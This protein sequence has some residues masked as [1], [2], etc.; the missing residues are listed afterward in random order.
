MNNYFLPGVS[1]MFVLLVIVIIIQ[2]IRCRKIIIK[3]NWGIFYQLRIQNRLSKEL[4]N[5][6]VEK[7]LLEKI[8]R[9]KLNNSVQS[10]TSE[11]S[12]PPLEGA[13]G[14]LQ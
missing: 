13:G 6:K 8:L 1:G 11:I 12:C 3:K 2:H 5:T 4:E 7:E 10:P 9:S 14:G